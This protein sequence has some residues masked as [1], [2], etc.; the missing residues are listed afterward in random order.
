MGVSKVEINNADGTK[1]VLV[2][3]TGDTVTADTLAEGVTAHGA[4]G[5]EIIGTMEVGLDTSDATATASDIAEGKTAYVNGEKI[6]GS[7][8]TTTG[9]MYTCKKMVFREYESVTND[10]EFQGSVGK[11]LLIRPMDGYEIGLYAKASEF[12]D[13]EASDVAKGKTFTSVNGLKLTGTA[14]ATTVESNDNCEAYH[15][16]NKSTALDFKR[17]DGDIKVW[18]YGYYSASTY[19]KTTYTFVGDGYYTSS[20]YGTPSKTSKTFSIN[21]DGTLSGLPSNLTTVD[22]LVTKGI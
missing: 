6:E 18:G 2:D 17:T 13:A 4:D 15:I 1:N 21:S 20:M 5:E 8:H 12:G 11:N 16:T 10:I 9:I 14:E 7:V 3:L 22:L 19:S